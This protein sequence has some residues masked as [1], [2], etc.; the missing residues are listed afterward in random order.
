[1]SEVSKFGECVMIP[2]LFQISERGGRPGLRSLTVVRLMQM[3]RLTLLSLLCALAA[4]LSVGTPSLAARAPARAPA[5]ALVDVGAVSDVS[6]LL[7]LFPWDVGYDSARPVATAASTFD[8]HENDIAFQAFLLIGFPCA[9]TWFFL[10][11]PA[12]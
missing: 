7:A 3:L 11:T 8:G 1:M 5:A 6:S 9:V 4:G 2:S 10:K 12:D